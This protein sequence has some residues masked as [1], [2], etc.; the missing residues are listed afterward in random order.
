M[1][2][3][4]SLISVHKPSSIAFR[5]L[6]VALESARIILRLQLFAKAPADRLKLYLIEC[7]SIRRDLILDVLPAPKC[8]VLGLLVNLSLAS[9]SNYLLRGVTLQSIPGAG[10]D[11]GFQPLLFFWEW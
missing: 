8:L 4:S 5:S 1:P 6:A 11:R 10:L 9:S 7:D 2:T 3:A